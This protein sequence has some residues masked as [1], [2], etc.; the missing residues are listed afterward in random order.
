M[1]VLAG[2]AVLLVLATRTLPG[3]GPEVEIVIVYDNESAEGGIPSDWGFSAVVDFRGQRILFDSGTD[4]KLFMDNL[5]RLGIDPGSITHAVI[6]HR[7]PDH[8]N[9]IYRLGLKNRKMKVFFLD[10]FPP[11]AYEIAWAV[12]IPPQRVLGPLEIAPGAF[13]T[14]GVDGDP[15][16]QALL[17]ETSK[18]LVV[19]TG[20][21]HPGLPRMVQTAE[22][23]RGKS[24]VRLLLGGFHL[25]R[26]SDE[27]IRE[28]ID[29]L[30]ALNVQQVAPAHCTGEKAKS[31]FRREFGADY[32]PT[33]AGRRIAL[34]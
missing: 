18:G 12:G 14:G 21:S 20:C 29:R 15:P 4:P 26:H 3:A 31:L 10:S 28:V 23:Q 27:Q 22:A 30:K 24:A 13:T 11:D 32:W 19:L 16:E 34:E 17:L 8:R 2:A 9:G 33:G 7:H 6:S 5:A 1:R 25:M